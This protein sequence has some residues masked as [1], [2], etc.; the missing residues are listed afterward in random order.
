MHWNIRKAVSV[1]CIMCLI[2][3]LFSGCDS[4]N[5]LLKPLDGDGMVNTNAPLV[6]AIQGDWIS[7]DG[8]FELKVVDYQMTFSLNGETVL[9]CGYMFSFAD[10]D[11]NIHT[12]F[13]LYFNELEHENTTFAVI[14]AF[15]YENGTFTAELTYTNG[16]TETVTLLRAEARNSDS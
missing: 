3:G 7:N 9:D 15:Y 4:G 11:I 2:S 14:K 8:K 10:E 13:E 1:M 5:G 6:N 12:D 16:D